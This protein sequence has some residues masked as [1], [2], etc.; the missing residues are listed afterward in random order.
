[1]LGKL[2]EPD[3]IGSFMRRPAELIAILTREAAHAARGLRRSPGFSIAVIAILG[4]GIGANAAVFSVVDRLLFRPAALLRDPATV[5][6]VYTQTWNRGTSTTRADAEYTRYLDLIRWTR[7]FS[8]FA[9]FSNRVLAV[10]DG[11]ASRERPVGIVSASFFH[12][13]D[14]PP[15]LGR[16]F[17]ADEDAIPRGADVAVL[18]Y[19]AWQADFGGR[20]VRGRALQVGN[21]RATIIGVA[22]RGFAGVSMTGAPAVYIPITTFAAAN[23]NRRDATAFFTSYSWRWMEIMV[24]RM[25]GV[26]AEDASADATLA[27]RQSWN[28]R[29]ELEPTLP[30]VDEAKPRAIVGSLHTGAGPEPGLE[31][32][33]ARWVAG[34][35]LVVLVIACANVANLFLARGL[36]RRR[37]IAVR[38][39][40]GV[41]RRRL[42][43]LAVVE[44]LMLSMVGGLAGLALAQWTGAAI[45][46]LL[47]G[48]EGVAA[49]AFTDWR[50]IAAATACAILAG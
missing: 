2:L 28:R 32:R 6:R 30:P 40:L 50:T 27:L 47:L 23:G 26:G 46:R 10:G 7:S 9:A 5:H 8:E 1:M 29:R 24:R 49:S 39:A 21:I 42:A 15:A 14:A 35:A 37:E 22:P 11:L 12:F 43:V 45:G 33:T 3:P 31:A 41:S 36:R 48:T 13:F 18:G 4:L 38:L 44:S 19:D 16:Y 20:D 17:A 25:P 34:V